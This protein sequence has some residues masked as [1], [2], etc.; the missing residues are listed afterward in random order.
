MRPEPHAE[1]VQMRLHAGDV[2]LHA[3]DI[4]QCG[5]GVEGVKV[6]DA[7]EGGV[8][9]ADTVGRLAR[10]VFNAGLICH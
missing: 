6:H 7:S 3:V 4:D 9:D 10:V 8:V 1:R 2:A 5:G